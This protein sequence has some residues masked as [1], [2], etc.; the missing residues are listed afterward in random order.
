MSVETMPDA[1]TSAA[2]TGR[3]LTLLGAAPPALAAQQA[4]AA[5]VERVLRQAGTSGERLT[6]ALYLILSEHTATT[7]AAGSES[8]QL[9]CRRCGP[10]NREWAARY[11]CPTAE[12][13]FWALDAA[14]S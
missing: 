9:Q 14:Y 4:F 12:Q 7:V 8:P 11:P 3:P 2:S 5:E 6:I 1:S 13:A 10:V